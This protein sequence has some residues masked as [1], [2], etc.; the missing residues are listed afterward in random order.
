MAVLSLIGRGRVV[1]ARQLVRN[2][3]PVLALPQNP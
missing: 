2:H 3:E 1:G